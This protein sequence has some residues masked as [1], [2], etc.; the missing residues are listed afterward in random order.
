DVPYPRIPVV[1]MP[2]FSSSRVSRD[3]ILDGCVDDLQ[4][5]IALLPW[6]GESGMPVERL[7]KNAAYGLLARVA[8]YAAGYSLRW[9]LQSYSPATVQL[10]SRAD[11]QRVRQLYEIAR[12]ACKA[13]VD[14]GENDLIDYETIFR[15][16]VNG[17]YNKE[18]MFEY[19]QK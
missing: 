7:S 19:G 10:G 15:D 8:L 3:T 14:R 16:L 1:D 11:G 9:G 17:R 4:Q 2:S 18:S 12:D 6:K 13:V 5:A